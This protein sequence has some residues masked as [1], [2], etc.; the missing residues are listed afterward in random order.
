M[1]LCMS[2]QQFELSEVVLKLLCY[3]QFVKSILIFFIALNG[4]VLRESFKG[5]S[6]FLCLFI[7]CFDRKKK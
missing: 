3:T 2:C 5:V 6:Y 1:H 7:T 4:Q